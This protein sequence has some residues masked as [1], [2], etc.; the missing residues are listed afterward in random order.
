MRFAEDLRVL[1]AITLHQLITIITISKLIIIKIWER[2]SCLNT[3][4][5]VP[6]IIMAIIMVIKPKSI[7]MVDRENNLS[8]KNICMRITVSSNI[9]QSIGRP[10]LMEARRVSKMTRSLAKIIATIIQPIIKKISI[11]TNLRTQGFPPTM[12]EKTAQVE[13]NQ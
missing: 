11:L 2:R 9:I 8:I 1:T 6:L 12:R 4:I 13:S 3:L 7:I 5:W 10:L